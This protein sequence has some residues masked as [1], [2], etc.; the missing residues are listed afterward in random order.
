MVIPH[1]TT[2]GFYT[3]AG[4]AWDKQLDRRQHDPKRQ[5]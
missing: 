2:W 5:T 3:P 4:S 1:G